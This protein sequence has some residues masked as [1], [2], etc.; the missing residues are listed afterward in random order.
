MQFYRQYDQIR[1]GI[2]ITVTVIFAV[3]GLFLLKANKYK[4]LHLLV[5][6]GILAVVIIIPGG[7]I[8]L[9]YRIRLIYSNFLIIWRVNN[10]EILIKEIL[11]M[12]ISI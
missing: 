5:I 7:S 2:S 3:K 11:V 1:A 4:G 9:N 12:V 10:P 8:V 6:F